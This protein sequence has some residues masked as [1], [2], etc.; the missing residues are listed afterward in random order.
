MFTVKSFYRALISKFQVPIRNLFWLIKIPLKVQIFLWYL[1]RGVVLTKDNLLKRN[2]RGNKQC[3][4]CIK[5]ETIQH[6]FIDCPVARLAWWV[7]RCVFNLTPPVSIE[8]MFGNWLTGIPTKLKSQLLVGASA[9]CWSIWCCRND[10]V[11]NKKMITNPLQV[12]FLCGFWLRAWATLQKSDQREYMVDG[13][14]R[15][16]AIAKQILNSH[17]WRFSHRIGN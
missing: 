15:L 3:C 9:L 12:I 2:W 17:G 14:L 16:E 10:V 13:S 5:D 1:K 4:F 8:N 7:V 6:L 11:F